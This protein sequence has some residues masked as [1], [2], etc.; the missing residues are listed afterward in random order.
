MLLSSTASGSVSG[1][2]LLASEV[3][4]NWRT[5]I[6][7]WLKCRLETFVWP[8]DMGIWLMG[9]RCSVIEER[10]F[11]IWAAVTLLIPGWNMKILDSTTKTINTQ[12]TTN[13][14]NTVDIWSIISLFWPIRGHYSV[15]VILLDQSEVSIIVPET[16]EVLKVRGMQHVWTWLD[17]KRGTAEELIAPTFNR[18]TS[19]ILLCLGGY[20]SLPINLK[21]TNYITVK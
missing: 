1:A 8:R 20:W 6:D 17:N 14:S 2:K 16:N 5:M 15:H 7:D 12:K 4:C 18:Y 21:T 9:Y 11:I 3:T 13:N 19:T 10:A